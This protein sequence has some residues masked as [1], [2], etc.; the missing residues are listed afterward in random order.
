MPDRSH[1]WRHKKERTTGVTLSLSVPFVYLSQT[2]HG[3]EHESRGGE[4][5]RRSASEVLPSPP[6]PKRKRG[7]AATG[8][9]SDVRGRP[10][11]E[12]NRAS[13]EDPPSVAPSPAQ[14]SVVSFPLITLLL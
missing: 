8:G 14:V 1:I 6:G 4:S 3:G 10:M 9:G 7:G 5:G 2:D 13:D 11:G 12:N